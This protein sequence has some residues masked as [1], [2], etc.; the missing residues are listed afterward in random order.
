M[1]MVH[2]PLSCY[3][4]VT[5]ST[6]HHGPDVLCCVVLYCR[7]GEYHSSRAWCTVLCRVTFPSRWES[8]ITGLMYCSLSCYIAVT[9]ST[10]HH[11]PDV[12]CC[13]VLHCRNGEYHSS[14]A[15]CTVLCRVTV[16]SRWGPIITGLMYCS[17]SCYI[18]VTVSTDHHVPYVLFCVVL[19]C[20]HGEY[21][22][23]RA[24]CTVLCRVTL[25]SRWV[26]IITCLMYCAVSCYIA[27]TVSTD[28][29]V[30]YVLFCVVLHCRHGEYRS[31][32][33]WC[34]VL[35]RVTL[36]SR[37]VPIVTCLHCAVSCYIAV[38]ANITVV[39]T[40]IEYNT[41]WLI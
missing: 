31:S 22:S 30:P 19:H 39:W 29:H 18:A 20:H 27:V 36:P 34:T 10:D 24:W 21:R 4:A 16:P 41:D 14:R 1:S 5:V 37:W 23:S 26:P 11:V 3:I 6:D 40:D 7:H 25:P 8:L 33:A 15:W 13:V 12:L 32:R 28:H 38:T 35:Y 9:V 17:V 2:C